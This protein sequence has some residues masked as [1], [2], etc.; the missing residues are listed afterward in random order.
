MKKITLLTLA[1]SAFLGASAQISLEKEDIIKKDKAYKIYNV[2]D[3]MW[4]RISDTVDFGTSG[5]N[6][7]Y[8]LRN[9]KK[10][11]YDTTYLLLND[12]SNYDFGSEHPNANAGALTDIQRYYFRDPISFEKADF[13]KAGDTFNYVSKNPN[14]SWGGNLLDFIWLAKGANSRFDFEIIDIFNDTTLSDSLKYLKPKVTPFASNFTD[15]TAAKIQ[16]QQVVNGDTVIQ[17]FEYY[18]ELNNDYVNY[19]IGARVDKGFLTTQTPSNQYAMVTSKINSPIKK[20]STTQQ[21]GDSTVTQ[22][23]WR[24]SFTEGVLQLNHFDLTTTT[25]KVMGYGTLYLPHD[26]FQV[27]QIGLTTVHNS[28]DS[29]FVFGSLSQVDA[30]LDTTFEILYYAKGYGEPIAKIE[31][32]RDTT[33][34]LSFQYLNVPNVAQFSEEKSSV[35]SEFYSFFDIQDN[36]AS[37]TGQSMIMDQGAFFGNGPTG[38]FDTIHAPF[39][40]KQLMVSTDMVYGFGHADTVNYEINY[41]P[42]G[43][44]TYRIRTTEIRTVGVDGYGTLY[45]NEDTAQVLRVVIAK[46]ERQEVS[47]LIGGFPIQSFNNNSFSYEMEFWGKQAQIPLAQ[48]QFDTSDFAFAYSC[49]YTD[50]PEITVGLSKK[51]SN[52]SISVY[53]NPAKDLFFVNGIENNNYQILVFETSG[54]EVYNSTFSGKAMVNT[55]A[56]DKG[57]YLVKTTNTANGSIAVE[58]LIIE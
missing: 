51:P 38:I 46:E 19:A 33:Q 17:I 6:G 25:N 10:L 7:V 37:I 36:K 39:N 5:A 50:V 4:W 27:M 26:S 13:P 9:L 43:G 16:E 3:S 21:F 12:K 41:N 54:K 11:G 28:V 23:L 34:A 53:P 20:H 15:A 24:A 44:F 35:I 32:N 22:S 8:D 48:A 52:E 58:R 29:I 42:G 55:Q 31:I 14:L 47:I 30:N 40:K 1:V 57:I 56:W 45:L 49:Q 18:K 2:A